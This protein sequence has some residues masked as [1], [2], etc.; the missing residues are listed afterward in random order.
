MAFTLKVYKKTQKTRTTAANPSD[1]A[2]STAAPTVKAG[3]KNSNGP[4][5]GSNKSKAVFN[6][7][8]MKIGANTSA[9]PKVT[10][11][12]L[13]TTPKTPFNGSD[14]LNYRMLRRSK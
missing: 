12:K 14:R 11:A 13:N 4:K 6:N 1:K 9:A 7:R 8:V 5:G 2:Q 10:K 3:P